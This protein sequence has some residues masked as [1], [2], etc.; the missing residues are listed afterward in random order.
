MSEKNADNKYLYFKDGDVELI[1][2]YLEENSKDYGDDEERY[3]AKLLHSLN[4]NDYEKEIGQTL[5]PVKECCRKMD[6]SEYIAL[7]LRGKLDNV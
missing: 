7:K 4:D 1:Y 3:K 5:Y 6:I 2:E